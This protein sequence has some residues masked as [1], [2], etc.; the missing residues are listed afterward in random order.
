MKS[1]GDFRRHTLCRAGEL[2][3]LA[4][5]GACVETK[6]LGALFFWRTG[7]NFQHNRSLALAPVRHTEFLDEVFGVRLHLVTKEILPEFS[8]IG[9]F[10]YSFLALWQFRGIKVKSSLGSSVSHAKSLVRWSPP[11]LERQKKEE[12]RLYTN[13]DVPSSDVTDTVWGRPSL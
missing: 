4:T 11:M 1:H 8:W 12:V 13:W 3:F 9:Q 7:A 6:S 10:F 5:E 2:S